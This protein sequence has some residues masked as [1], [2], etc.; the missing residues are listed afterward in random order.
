MRG[1]EL[2]TFLLERAG[3]SWDGMPIAGIDISELDRE[4]M[5]AFRDKA[6][7]NG[8]HTR[9]EMNVSDLQMLVDQRLLDRTQKEQHLV[10][11]AAMLFHPEPEI[12]AVGA[13]IK[14]AYFAPEG[15][16]GANK[17]D[18][19]IYHDTIRG[20]LITQADRAVDMLYTKYLKALVDYEGLQRKET[21]MVPRDAMRE[22]L[23]NAINHKVYESGNPIQISVFDDHIMVF[24]QGYWP[25]DI[26]TGKVYEWHT[27]YP[28]NPVMSGVFFSS[29]DI[30]AYGS[31]FN[32]I[33]IACDKYGAPY[34][35]VIATPNGVTVEIRACDRYMKLLKHGRY[36][37]TYPD[38]SDE[39]AYGGNN[40]TVT[41]QGGEDSISGD[42]TRRLDKK[43]ERILDHI[44]DT[45]STKLSELEKR[46][47]MPIYEYLKT[48]DV[49][50]SAK[51]MEL[52][53]KSSS[54]VNRYLQRLM[55]LNVLK[56]EGGS[57]NTVYRRTVM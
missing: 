34:P 27:S 5:D 11:A 45:L 35:T 38:F 16:Y 6:V 24:N 56:R 15:A 52:T 29:G 31:G 13:Y 22:I 9:E 19:I 4:A 41:A 43:T 42:E 48:N 37:D 39:E 25:S 8:R 2:S 1:A 26:D 57:K 21:Y 7:E 36:W 53:G 32:K 55:E 23:L 50:D 10:R 54:T 46:N 14:I 18:D 40:E 44:S 12:F 47:I 49:I 3:K 30:E 28:H 33:R 17:S 20:P 51:A